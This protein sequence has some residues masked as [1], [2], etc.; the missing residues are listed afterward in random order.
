MLPEIYKVDR[1]NIWNFSQNRPELVIQDAAR[2]LGLDEEEQDKLRTI[3]LARGVAKWLKVRRDLV[4]HKCNLRV[5]I[6]AKST[7][8]RARKVALDAAEFWSPAWH[9]LHKDWRLAKAEL[10][11]LEGERATIAAMCKSDRL[12]E[13]PRSTSKSSMKTMN[14]VKVMR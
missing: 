8:V 1:T 9:K 12:V 6:R 7:E 2:Y 3:L 14:T 10:K 5:R 4:A 13:W 11:L